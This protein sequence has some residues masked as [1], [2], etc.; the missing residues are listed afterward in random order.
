MDYVNFLRMAAWF[1]KIKYNKGVPPHFLCPLCSPTL[2]FRPPWVPFLSPDAFRSHALFF[3]FIF[4]LPSFHSSLFLPLYPIAFFLLS[5][6]LSFRLC[7]YVCLSRIPLFVLPLCLYLSIKHHISLPIPPLDP[8]LLAPL[9]TRSLQGAHF[10]LG[11][12]LRPAK[13]A[14]ALYKRLGLLPSSWKSAA[15]DPQ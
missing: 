2:S 11:K 5:L 3:R 8:Q 4:F 15:R 1:V 9:S 7:V 12:P 6:S 10:W 14:S 13:S